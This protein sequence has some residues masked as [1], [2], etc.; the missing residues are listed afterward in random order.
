MTED[1]RKAR[2][3]ELLERM[4]PLSARMVE[5]LRVRSA[6]EA[7]RS[8]EPL[9]TSERD[10]LARALQEIDQEYETI[11]ATH[12]GLTRNLLSELDTLTAGEPIDS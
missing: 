9:T 12:A 11:S 2:A 7:R 8:A 3:R 5:L 1:E 4:M 10:E 6:I